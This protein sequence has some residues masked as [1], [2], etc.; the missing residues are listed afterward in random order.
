MYM[1]SYQVE[2]ESQYDD[3]DGLISIF[4]ISDKLNIILKY[5]ESIEDEAGDILVSGTSN[6]TK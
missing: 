1:Q 4:N 3:N 6:Q 5:C 2:N